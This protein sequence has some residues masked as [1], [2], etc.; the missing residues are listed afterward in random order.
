MMSIS[1][2]NCYELVKQRNFTQKY[3]LLHNLRNYEG[4]LV[5]VAGNK[6][7]LSAANVAPLKGYYLYYLTVMVRF[8]FLL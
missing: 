7:N 6:I 8:N 3:R 4:L 2:N 1:K 5:E